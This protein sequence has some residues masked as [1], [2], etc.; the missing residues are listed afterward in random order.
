MQTG[1]DLPPPEAGAREHSE[2]VRELVAG[3]IAAGG[4]FLSFADYMDAVLYAPGFGYYSAGAEKFGAAGDFVTAPELGHVF[5]RCLARVAGA[6]L[7]Q[8]GGGSILEVGGGSGAL[9]AD[10]L[11]A[12]RGTPPERY[13]LLD[14][15]GDLRER[16][17]RAIEARV[18]EMLHR[19][20]WLDALPRAPL[21]GV[22]LANEVLDALPVERFRIGRDELEQQ[23][24]RIADGGLAWAARPSPA[25]LAAAIRHLEVQLGAP[26]AEGYT[27]EIG[28][29]HAPWLRALLASLDR[30]L[31]LCI[32]YGG[33]RRDVYHPG[34]QDGTLTCH[35]R[36]RRHNDP[37]VLPGLQDLTAWVDFSAVA[38]AAVESGFEVVAYATQAHVLLASGILDDL[39]AGAD[40]VDPRRLREMQEVQRLLLPGEMGERFKVL[41]LARGFTPDSPLTVRDLRD[42]L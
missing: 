21:T 5:A 17:R 8:L 39:Q 26:L 36:H 3:R 34:R 1:F 16:Q 12:L 32:D 11:L 31:A 6:A 15:S 4:G 40:E 30:G 33:T 37:F 9:A 20:T 14:V 23:G 19:V 10:L 41:A 42:R 7:R 13:L 18:P 28:L 27:S 22:L 29:R 24:V 25:P 35:Y 38:A 2:R